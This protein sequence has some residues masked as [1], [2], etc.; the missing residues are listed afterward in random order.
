MRWALSGALPVIGLVSLISMAAGTMDAL[1]ALI[2]GWVVDATLASSAETYFSANAGLLIG[3]AAFFLLMRPILIGMNW[4]MLGV[5][6]APSIFTLVLSR[7]NTHVLGQSV[8]FYD[9]EF[10]GRLAQ[11][12]LQA[13]QATTDLVNDFVQAILYSAAS[14]I[15]STIVLI[16]IDGVTALAL[17]AWLVAYLI[18]VHA[19]MPRVRAASSGRAAARATVTGQVVDTATNIRTVKLFGHANRENQAAMD[20][21]KLY[22]KQSLHFGGIFAGFRF[23]QVMLAGALPVILVGTTVFQWSN[24]NATTGDIAAAGT[25]ALKMVTMSGWISSTLMAIY[26]NIG[27]AEDAI[28]TLTPEHD[29]VDLPDADDLTVTAG[30]IRF[31]NVHFS[32]EGGQGLHGIDLEVRPGEKVGIVG[33]SGAGKSTL[34]S[35]LLRLHDIESGRITIDAQDVQEVTQDSLRRQISIVTQDTALFNRSAKENI[36]YG[37]PDASQEEIE[38]AARRA[39]AH[40]FILTLSDNHG[41]AGYDAQL[42]ERGVKIS[43]GQR[44]RIAL[45]RA[46]L[47]DA[48][49]LVLDEATSA[50]DSKVEAQIQAA[51]EKAMD[52]KTVIA[53]AHRLSTLANMDRIIVMDG[54]RI[55]E[56]G[57]HDDLMARDGIYADLWRRQLGREDD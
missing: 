38:A 11:K 44:Q 14:V 15:A 16:A 36:A 55:A 48:Q 2:L 52:G 32:Y 26:T 57:T 9:N 34:V 20:A 25:I 47:K 28:Q 42:G 30:A 6:L 29:L 17:A 46:M 18:L 33:P 5:V 1:T 22:R 24:G 19:Y 49:I 3:A 51:L 27:E 53:I 13:A 10:A 39:E 40:D 12:Q 50:L 8:D 21:M 23:W 56:C 41:R 43:G 4:L 35:A 7:V 45:S 31:D 54:G 37:R